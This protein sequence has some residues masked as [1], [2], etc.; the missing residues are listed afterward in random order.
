MSKSTASPVPLAPLAQPGILARLPR[1]GRYLFFSVAQAD[2]IPCCLE[3]L[4]SVADGETVVTGL[5]PLC[6]AALGDRVAAPV[7]GLRELKALTG[8]EVGVSVPSTPTALC[9]WLRGDD[10][11]DLI[12]LTQHLENLLA[13]GFHLDRV[14]DAFT[15][16]KGPNG[17]GRDLTGYE[18]GIENPKGNAALDAALLKG[19]G[20]GLDGSSF[21]AV[22]QWLHDF[23]AFDAMSSQM[24][25][26][27]F[28]RRR[29]DSEELNSAPASAHVKRTAQESFDPEAFVLRRSMPWAV[30]GKAGLMFV[31]FGKSFDAFEVQMRRMAGLEDGIADALFR[32]SRPLSGANFWCPPMRSGRLDLRAL[33]L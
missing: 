25:D 3:L 11:G 27:V 21:V 15:H 19:C 29:G 16:G 4:S 23:L 14:I 24:Q 30:G 5:G 32:I 6:L 31:A 17:F 7:P 10:Q 9:C 8:R 33:K 22:Q 12:H 28:G 2:E 20:A 18:D 1:V 13:P 26:H